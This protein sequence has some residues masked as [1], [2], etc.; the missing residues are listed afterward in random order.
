MEEFIETLIVLP[1]V[2]VQK[3]TVSWQGA[4]SM[5]AYGGYILSQRLSENH[6]AIPIGNVQ[7]PEVLS[8]VRAVGLLPP[9][10][11]VRLLPVEHPLSVLLCIFDEECFERVTE[12]SRQEW[13]EHLGSLVTMRNQR[14]ESLMQEIMA[15]LQQPGFGQEL[16][17]ESVAQML[18]VELARFKRTLDGRALTQRKHQA[19]APWQLR[20]IEERVQSALHLG[21]P[22]L[23][24]LAELCGFSQ[25]HLARSFKAATGWQI[26]RYITNERFNT[27]KDLLRTSGLSCEEVA[28]R[29]DFKSAA[30][31]S[32]AFR[33]ATGVTP[34]EFRRT[35]SAAD[36]TPPETRSISA[37][38]VQVSSAALLTRRQAAPESVVSG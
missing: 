38:V 8:R 6:A 12:T 29:L 37:A 24:E 9:G 1:C 10:C 15:E 19:L 21:Y 2:T 5:P 32:T 27:A 31:F 28:A 16:L 4:I 14:L 11:P 36:A 13:D 25:G 23:T 22:S 34:S 35:V 26:H 30:Y 33:R 18:M 20:T 17:V 3:V 7:A